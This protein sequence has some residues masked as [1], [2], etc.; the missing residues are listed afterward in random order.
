MLK[1]RKVMTGSLA[2]G[3]YVASLD[4]PWLETP[5]LLQGFYIETEHDIEELAKYCDYVLIDEGFTRNVGRNNPFLK[6]RK[7]LTPSDLFPHTRLRSYIDSVAYPEIGEDL[8]VHGT[9]W[10]FSDYKPKFGHAPGLG[11]HNAE[12][13][14]S[15]GYS[16]AE[17][18]AFV[19]RKVV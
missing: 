3:M 15:V 11:Q 5:F 4:R 14:A 13:L 2:I 19:E 10:Q 7:R 8:K 1:Q 9:P 17:I 12:L 18:A 16:E 6:T